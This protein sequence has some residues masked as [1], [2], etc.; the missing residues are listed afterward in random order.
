[1]RKIKFANGEYYHIFN[2]GV[3][4]RVIFP[5]TTDLSRFFKSMIEFNSIEPIGSIFENSFRK[6]K[7]GNLVSQQDKLIDYICYCLNPNHYHFILEQL[8]D[9][10][11]EKFMHRLNLGYTKYLN[12][13]Y[14]RNGSL[15]QGTFKAIHIDSDEYLLHLSAYVNLNNRVHDIESL[16]FDSSW[17]EYTNTKNINGLCKKD[18]ILKQFKNISDYS[19]FA[20]D[21]RKSIKEKKELERF[22]LE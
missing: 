22:L 6:D 13:K 18:I 21:S 4:K 3:D 5:E 16:T 17:D 19:D 9:N 15:F 20:E 2:R 10:G 11:I 14:D 8:S 12:R 7:L 1:M